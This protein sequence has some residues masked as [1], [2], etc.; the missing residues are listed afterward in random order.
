MHIAFPRKAARGKKHPQTLFPA[1]TT[2]R[3]GRGS[4]AMAVMMR[5]LAR[6]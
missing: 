2:G 6:W 5:S 3:T 4:A 1:Y